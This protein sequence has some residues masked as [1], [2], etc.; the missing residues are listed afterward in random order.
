VADIVDLLLSAITKHLPVARLPLPIRNMVAH[1]F[2]SQSMID[3]VRMHEILDQLVFRSKFRFHLH[4]RVLRRAAETLT[5]D[6][7]STQ[8][9]GERTTE[10]P[11]AVWNQLDLDFHDFD[12][13]TKE[14]L[15]ALRAFLLYL[16]DDGLADFATDLSPI[17]AHG[18]RSTYV[19]SEK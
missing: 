11:V 9:Q 16:P 7:G 10:R 8:H 5:A 18:V 1:R 6:F 14:T 17:L 12:L 3:Y 4:I 13:I 19:R 15:L 2:R